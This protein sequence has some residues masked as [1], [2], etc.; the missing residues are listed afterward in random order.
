MLELYKA[1]LA[2]SHFLESQR[3]QR[4]VKKDSLFLEELKTESSVWLTSDNVDDK[5]VPEL[6][7]DIQTKF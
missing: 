7:F 2:K 5:I 1:R 4:Q 3:K 6:L